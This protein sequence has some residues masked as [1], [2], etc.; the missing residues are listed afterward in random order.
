MKKRI[1]YIVFAL[2]FIF[3]LA[4]CTKNEENQNNGNNN[5]NITPPDPNGGS[6]GNNN[7]KKEEEPT[8]PDEYYTNLVDTSSAYKFSINNLVFPLSLQDFTDRIAV[9]D[10]YVEFN[11]TEDYDFEVYGDIIYTVYKKSEHKHAKFYV[12]NTDAYYVLT[13][14]STNTD[15][16]AHV[17]ILEIEDVAPF[18][19]ILNAELTKYFN[20]NISGIL[21][22]KELK[23]SI[24]SN[25]E[26]SFAKVL[27]AVLKYDI[28]ENITG[29]L[30]VD[31]LRELNN[32]LATEPA[33]TTIDSI[34]G[35]FTFLTIKNLLCGTISKSIFDY[36]LSDI[37]LAEQY[38]AL[39]LD[40][41]VADIDTY[42]PKINALLGKNKLPFNSV[43][44]IMKLVAAKFEIEIAEDI[45]LK[46]FLQLEALTSLSIN[47]IIDKFVGTHI[48]LKKVSKDICDLC[49]KYSFYDLINAF[50][51]ATS[52]D[53]VP[54][55]IATAGDVGIKST[56]DTAISFI[57][58]INLTVLT[59]DKGNLTKATLNLTQNLLIVDFDI[60]L[61]KI[62]FENK[63][64]FK[65][66]VL[67]NL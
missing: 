2:F 61:T 51:S 66:L 4:S 30:N 34:V 21:T 9:E 5:N 39:S 40:E 53:Q 27:D 41:A 44:D 62:T 1:I 31:A 7:Q 17:D 42:L 49:Y 29:S 48:D 20:L 10:S 11:L 19:N 64:E 52:I 50:A 36:K 56:V 24:V 35:P 47:D 22:N 58:L 15:L 32:R 14:L 13:D 6:G 38:S 33:A 46:D 54:D 45:T 3:S 16:Y 67:E 23:Q 8:L 55:V 65:A 12:L 57:D 18:I 26:Q 43:S 28:Q 60:E 25:I 59:D 37:S 63:D